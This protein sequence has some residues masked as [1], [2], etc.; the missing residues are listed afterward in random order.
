MAENDDERP[1]PKD[2]LP[3]LGTRANANLGSLQQA[4][5]LVNDLREATGRERRRTGEDAHVYGTKIVIL[6]KTLAELHFQRRS[7]LE[8]VR[9]DIGLP[10][11]TL[12]DWVRVA[13]YATAE[14]SRWGVATC[15]AAGRL[16]EFFAEH[17]E[18]RRAAGL[19]RKPETITDLL[20]VAFPLEDGRTVRFEGEQVFADDVEAALEFQRGGVKPQRGLTNAQRTGNEK[21]RAAAASVPEL[22]GV[23]AQLRRKAGR[24]VLRV[25]IPAGANLVEIARALERV[26]GR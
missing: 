2:E 11:S 18:K 16:V 17:D 26:L 1:K 25:D 23:A 19:K 9:E 5:M 10:R 21:L 7:F 22:K 15:L 8:F 4:Q 12:N 6:Y 14:Q 24:N 3:V 20:G 13:R